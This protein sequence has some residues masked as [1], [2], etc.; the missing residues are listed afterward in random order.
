MFFV[1][2][3]CSQKIAANVLE[4]WSLPLEKMEWR[5]CKFLALFSESEFNFIFDAHHFR[6]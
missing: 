4:D 2:N 5:S 3:Q 6:V 1:E